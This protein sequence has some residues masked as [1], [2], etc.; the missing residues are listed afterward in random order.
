MKYNGIIEKKIRVIEE[1]LSD[2]EG[3]NISSFAMLQ[4]N[5]MLQRAVERELQIAIEAIIDVSERILALEKQYPPGTSADAI[6]KLQELGIIPANREYI[7]M[8]NFRDFIV[9]RYEKIDLEII[10]VT[11]KTKLSVFKEFI[12]AI[13]STK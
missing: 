7:D 2:I 8:I 6:N 5:V 10:Y 13:R 3:W 11:I 4:K 9:H 12:D 1:M